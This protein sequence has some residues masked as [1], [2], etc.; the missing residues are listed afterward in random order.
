M[1]PFIIGVSGGSGSGKTTLA[2][3]LQ[4]ELGPE[5]A[6]ILYQDSYYIDQSHRF[7]KDGGA[8][9]FDHPDALEFSA[10]FKHLQQLKNEE[11]IEVPVYEFATHKRL[12]RTT[13]FPPKPVVI[14]E[15]ILIYALPEFLKYFDL[16]VFVDAPEDIRYARRLRRDTE[17]RGRTEEGV[18]QQFYNQVAPMH[19]RFVESTKANAHILCDGTTP[20]ESD[21][22]EILAYIHEQEPH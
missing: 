4:A 8:V 7:D 11:T 1:K 3:R 16:S 5:R 21:I 14:V 17:E 6:A 12:E 22:S 2:N 9:N 20:F 10:L 19:N 13:T 15:G 18:Y